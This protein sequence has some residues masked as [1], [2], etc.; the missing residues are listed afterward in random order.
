[1]NS[2]TPLLDW[3]DTSIPSGAASFDHYVL[4]IADNAGFSS[5]LV[6]QNGFGH[7]SGAP[8]SAL[9]PN[10][11]WYWH[12]Q[13]C[14]TNAEC[15]AWTSAR[16]FRTKLSPPVAIA[17]VGAATVASLKPTFS[18]KAVSGAACYA[19]QVSKV[20]SFSTLLVNV[21]ISK[22]ASTYTPGSSLPASTPLF[23]RIRTNGA[24][25]PSSWMSYESFTTP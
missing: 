16:T 19:L 10:T 24:N 2:Y 11:L 3:S 21:S 14:N 15:S 1:V 9:P 17:P 5:P 25:G 18:W 6:T 20:T 23:W 4:Q 7:S 22:T 12:V 8:A 13:A